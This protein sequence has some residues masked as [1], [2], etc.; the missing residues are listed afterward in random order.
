[1]LVAKL[2]GSLKINVN[3]DKPWQKTQYTRSQQGEA[4]REDGYI[5]TTA[6]EKTAD[7]ASAAR[8]TAASYSTEETAASRARRPAEGAA[9]SE[10]PPVPVNETTRAFDKQEAKLRGVRTGLTVLSVFGYAATAVTALVLNIVAHIFSFPLGLAIGIPGII[11]AA[12]GFCLAARAGMTREINKHRRYAAV[13]GTRKAVPL[14]EIAKAMDL[15]VPTVRRDLK[16]M[17]DNGVFLPTPA[18]IDSETGVFALGPQYVTAGSASAPRAKPEERAKQSENVDEYERILR[19]LRLLNGDIADVSISHKI[20]RIEQTSAQIFRTVREYPDK[21]P[22]IRK[23]MNYYLPTTLKLLQSYAKYEREGIS[24][25]NVEKAKSDIDRV[26]GKLAD[27]FSE[28]L[29]LLYK[30]DVLD[31][32][33]DITVLENMMERDGLTGASAFGGA[34][35]AIAEL[36]ETDASEPDSGA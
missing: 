12:S 23:L 22:Q 27:G 28:Q 1:M 32:A 10:K 20:E 5:R 11:C 17:I 21:L 16:K 6:R 2:I 14:S 15:P 36:A 25:E 30:T 33:A 34:S 13:I 26:L 3:S 9:K 31:I 29:N 7:A 4:P 18:M 24:G 35:A 19:T 8:N